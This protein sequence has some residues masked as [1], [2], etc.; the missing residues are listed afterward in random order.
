[1]REG[2]ENEEKEEKNGGNWKCGEKEVSRG[3]P[4]EGGKKG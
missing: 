2:K 1:M 4:G 3:K